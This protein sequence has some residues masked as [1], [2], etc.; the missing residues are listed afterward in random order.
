MGRYVLLIHG[1]EAAW[2]RASEAE[3]AE[4]YERYGKLLGQMQE[5][6]HVVAGDELAPAATAKVVR[7]G[8]GDAQITDGPFAET[9][10]QLGGFFLLDCDEATALAYAAQIPSRGAVEVRAIVPG[11]SD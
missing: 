5:H 10:E 2:E 7:R 9:R 11:P 4:M 3:R 6:G 8:D 1:E